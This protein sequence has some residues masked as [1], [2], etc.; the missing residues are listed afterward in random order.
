MGDIARGTGTGGLCSCAAN[1]LS[2]ERVLE[3]DITFFLEDGYGVFASLLLI[4]LLLHFF[5]ADT[6]AETVAIG[7]FVLCGMGVV[8]V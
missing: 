6:A 8:T 7:D 1:H 2:Y 5:L 4:L 3:G